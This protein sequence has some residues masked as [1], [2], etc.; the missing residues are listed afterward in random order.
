[1]QQTVIT[2]EVGFNERKSASAEACLMRGDGLELAGSRDASTG[3][4]LSVRRSSGLRN[5]MTRQRAEFLLR[6]LKPVDWGLLDSGRS[7]SWLQSA[8][9]GT[10]SQEEAFETLRDAL[11]ASVVFSLVK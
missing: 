5:W 10:I 2:G 7:F 4:L 1:M 11:F 8:I 3:L 6:V 9:G